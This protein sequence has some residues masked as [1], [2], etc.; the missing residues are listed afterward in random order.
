MTEHVLDVLTR[1]LGRRHAV[2]ALAAA[3]ATSSGGSLAGAESSKRKKNKKRKQKKAKKIDQQ[4]LALCAGQVAQCQTLIG[5]S[6][7][8]LF[9]CQELVECDFA[10][11]I[12]CLLAD[13]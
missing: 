5:G 2:Q 1:S 7:P 6:S 4:S 11:L 13:E 9:C 8:A 12:A 10:G 3:V